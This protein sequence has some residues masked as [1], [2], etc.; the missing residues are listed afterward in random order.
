MDRA[1]RLGWVLVAALVAGCADTNPTVDSSV[2]TDVYGPDWLA[3]KGDTI[4]AS[5]SEE[6]KQAPAALLIV[7]DRSSSMSTNGKWLA[8]QKAI[9]KAIDASAFDNLSLGLLAYPSFSI[10]APSCLLFVT[11][12]SCGVSSLPQVPL[13]DTGLL[14]STA[15]S[16]PR[17][18]IYTW[19]SAS[20]PDQTITDASPGYDALS[21]AIK[22]LQDHPIDGKRLLV[23]ITDGGFS[24]TSMSSP[25]RPGYS[26]GLC[27]DWEYPDTVIALLS[28]AR[29][30]AAKPVSSFIVGVPGSDSA[31]Q[32]QGPYSTAPYHMRLALS[33]YAYAGS[34]TT[35]PATC[36]GR[37]FTQSGADPSA[38]CHFD[39]TVGTFDADTLAQTI[40][41]IRGKAL[42]CTYTL[43][44]VVGKQVVNKDKV[45]VRV[46]IDG[47]GG[48]IPRRLIA[49]DPCTIK[50]CW[51][52]DALGQVELIG[53]TCD[54]VKSAANA[55]VEILVGCLT[56]L[57]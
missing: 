54:Q 5:V 12:V 56:I 2:Q 50:G 39:M 16:G 23:F 48:V 8:A 38:P 17:R 10:A 51:D 42:G 47:Q 36:D 31:G 21:T 13:G 44:K 22:A 29:S 41:D 49:T 43:P 25:T 52:Y 32:M 37:S 30:A 11:Q 24:C 26:D 53:K 3:T 40:A 6:A 15:A 27:P 1:S 35:V 20:G 19:L 33:A 7:L 57:E 4:C 9:V 14:K 45:N 18:E 28:A 46:T 34:P 55:K